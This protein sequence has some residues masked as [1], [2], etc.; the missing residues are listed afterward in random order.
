ME[1]SMFQ[2]C[3]PKLSIFILR[4]GYHLSDLW[5]PPSVAAILEMAGT[6]ALKIASLRSQKIS[7]PHEVLTLFIPT[8]QD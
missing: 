3:N 1:A 8:L 2:K 7:I 5:Y 6:L 4:L